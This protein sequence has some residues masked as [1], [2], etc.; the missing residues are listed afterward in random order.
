MLFGLAKAGH[1]Y[2]RMLDV[3]MK[4][5]DREFWISYL[6]DILTFRGETWAHFRHLAQVVQAHPAAGKDT[7]M[8]D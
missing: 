1:L 6:D 2:S 4:D 7:T 5:M 3:A 8:Q